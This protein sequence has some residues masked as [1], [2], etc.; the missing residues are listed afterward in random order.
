M[1]VLKLHETGIIIFTQNY[2][3][4]IAFYRDFVGLTI[5]VTKPEYTVF[6]WGYS[7]LMIEPFLPNHYVKADQ[8]GQ[9]SFI[10][11]LNVFQIDEAIIELQE[12]GVSVD[13]EKY[14]WGTVASFLDPDGN[15][16]ELKD[17]PDFFE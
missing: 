12:K 11:R 2:A 3:S 5:R 14:D 15:F 7:Y 16:L 6:S 9:A 8:C 17:A 13:V 10:I 4:M 1:T